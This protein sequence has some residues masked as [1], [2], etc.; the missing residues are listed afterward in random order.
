M[1]SWSRGWSPVSNALEA[2]LKSDAAHS[3]GNHSCQRAITNE[4]PQMGVFLCTG[5]RCVGA[6][7]SASVGVR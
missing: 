3:I 1:L 7:P 4:I 6:L 2:F 5:R